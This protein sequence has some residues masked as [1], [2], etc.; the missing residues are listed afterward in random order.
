MTMDSNKPAVKVNTN[1]L[2]KSPAAP[3]I[4]ATLCIAQTAV[5]AL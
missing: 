3:L 2:G 4:T 1:N 5:T